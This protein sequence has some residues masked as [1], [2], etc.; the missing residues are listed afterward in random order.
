MGRWSIILYCFGIL[1]F[2]S[3]N[4]R[5]LY[6]SPGYRQSN[7]ARC[8]SQPLGFVSEAT[9]SHLRGSL[10]PW[11]CSDHLQG[12]RK[13]EEP[14]SG[15]GQSGLFGLRCRGALCGRTLS[16]QVRYLSF[17][18]SYGDEIQYKQFFKL[19]WLFV[20]VSAP[21]HGT[22]GK[23][24]RWRACSNLP[25]AGAELQRQEAE[26]R[27]QKMLWNGVTYSTPCQK[28]AQYVLFEFCQHLLNSAP[29]Y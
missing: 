11:V 2:T 29:C 9:T 4:P 5:V 24:D 13:P 1:Y 16:S 17:I 6:F 15:T 26:S 25:L 19:I 8:Y 10:P 20:Q 3:L 28:L 12:K 21:V 23:P 18:M 14:G 22:L 27:Y 7:S